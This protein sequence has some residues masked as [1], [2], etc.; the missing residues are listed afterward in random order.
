M[1]TKLA[2]LPEAESEARAAFEWY[3]ERN[4]MAAQR[5]EDAV[6]HAMERILERPLAW[7]SHDAS[8][9]TRHFVLQRFPYSVIYRIEGETVT[10]VAVAHQRRRA[11]YW[12][13]R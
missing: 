4:P 7:P 6:E 13:G 5:F 2:I 8:A 12:R 11:G 9:G 3:L 10:V 1:P